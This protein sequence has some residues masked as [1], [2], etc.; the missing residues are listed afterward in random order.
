MNERDDSNEEEN[1]VDEVELEEKQNLLEEI[2]NLS[3]RDRVLLTNLILSSVGAMQLFV[4]ERDD[5]INPH[6]EKAATEHLEEWVESNH[7]LLKEELDDFKNEK[8]KSEDER[9]SEAN[10]WKKVKVSG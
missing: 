4:P 10:D 8:A 2:R 6:V 3:H 5:K 9:M 1:K 7:K